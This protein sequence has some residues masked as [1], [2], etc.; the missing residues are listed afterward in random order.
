MMPWSEVKSTEQSVRHHAAVHAWMRRQKGDLQV[1]QDIYDGSGN[2]GEDDGHTIADMSDVPRGLS[3]GIRNLF[4]GFS[5]EEHEH[6]EGE[7]E[8]NLRPWED[9][10]LSRKERW[11]CTLGALKA[12]L[13]IGSA[14]IVGLGAVI[15]LLI[16]FWD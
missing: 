7:T 13:L 2:G 16:L 15:L 11:I 4:G 3:G 12:A 5:P 8:E 9:T 6:P 10:S 1:K 14:Y